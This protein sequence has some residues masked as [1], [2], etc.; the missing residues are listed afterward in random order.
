MIKEIV[1]KISG[2]KVYEE[3]SVTDEY[4]EIVFFNKDIDIW[5]KILVDV[6]GPPKKA[7]GIKPDKED[8]A[9]TKNCGGIWDNQPLFKKDVDG[10]VMIAMFWPW[11]DEEHTT[12]KMSVLKRL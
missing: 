10:E 12:L 1:R 7:V 8:L 3:R 5:N 2:I 4:V 6:F 9:L 11:Q